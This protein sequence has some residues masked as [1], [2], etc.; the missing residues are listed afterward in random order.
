MARKSAAKKTTK[1]IKA[2]KR[3]LPSGK[4]FIRIPSTLHKALVTMAEVKGFKGKTGWTKF[5]LKNLN[6]VVKS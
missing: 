2:T 1:V 5:A 3:P 6:A 4:C